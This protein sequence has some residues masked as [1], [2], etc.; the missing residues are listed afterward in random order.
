MPPPPLQEMPYMVIRSDSEGG[1]GVQARA[2]STADIKKA[3]KKQATQ[4]FPD[5]RSAQTGAR[6]A[7]SVSSVVP[8]SARAVFLTWPALFAAMPWYWHLSQ[9]LPLL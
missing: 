5:R 6:L 8:P 2:A 7:G 4:A 1:R 3:Y 9:V